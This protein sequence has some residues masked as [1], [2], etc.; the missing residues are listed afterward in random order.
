VYVL[1]KFALFSQRQLAA[2]GSSWSKLARFLI[3]FEYILLLV[4]AF[5]Y[6]DFTL[7]FVTMSRDGAIQEQLRRREVARGN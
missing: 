4:H 7:N 6:A 3:Y 1:N 2:I 5:C